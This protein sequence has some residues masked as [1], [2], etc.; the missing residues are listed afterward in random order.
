MEKRIWL[1][2]LCHWL[3]AEFLSFYSIYT[4][5]VD[6]YTSMTILNT[7]LFVFIHANSI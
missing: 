4:Y 2:L 7:T 1:Q 3:K 6:S 5:I